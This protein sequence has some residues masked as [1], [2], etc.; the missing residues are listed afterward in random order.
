MPIAP[1]TG[2][3]I[4]PVPNRNQSANGSHNCY[5]YVHFMPVSSKRVTERARKLVVSTNFRELESQTSLS[6]CNSWRLCITYTRERR[7]GYTNISHVSHKFKM[8]VMFRL[9]WA[10]VDSALE[11]QSH[12]SMYTTLQTSSR[13]DPQGVSYVNQAILRKRTVTAA[14]AQTVD[15]RT[16]FF[17][18]SGLRTRLVC[19]QWF[20][21]TSFVMR[22]LHNHNS[23]SHLQQWIYQWYTVNLEI[24]VLYILVF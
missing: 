14:H 19:M 13:Y 6:I 24:F 21:S 23:N 8:L 22:L 3:G 2:C 20:Y 10:W 4:Q 1:P 12:V 7:F 17:Q 16:F 11:R 18:T 15:T 9:S 5:V